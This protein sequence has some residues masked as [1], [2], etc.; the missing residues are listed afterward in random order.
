MKVILNI[1]LNILVELNVLL[2]FFILF[3]VLK[4]LLISADGGLRKIS[5][6]SLGSL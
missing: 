6:C 1:N 2:L 3:M 4:S 5:R